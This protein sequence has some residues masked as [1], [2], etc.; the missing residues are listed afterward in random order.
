MKRIIASAVIGLAALSAYGADEGTV[1]PPTEAKVVKGQP[2]SSVVITQCNLL[3]A[4]YIT[5]ADGQLVRFDGD[6]GLPVDKVLQL[7]YEARSSQ[8]VECSCEELAPPQYSGSVKEDTI[9]L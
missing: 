5:T 1:I 2:V 9:N 4:V 6:S 7:A 3:V 8:R